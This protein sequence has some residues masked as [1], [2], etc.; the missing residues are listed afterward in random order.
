MSCIA[1]SAGGKARMWW[2]ICILA[3]MPV[4][5]PPLS[6]IHKFL[7]GLDIRRQRNLAYSGKL[8]RVISG[9]SRA[10]PEQ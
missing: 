1:L 5:Y 9:G 2:E 8:V 3:A 10:H 6:E 4:Y 7:S